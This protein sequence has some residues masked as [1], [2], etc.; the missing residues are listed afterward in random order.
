MA[1]RE[2]HCLKCDC[3]LGVIRDAKLKIGIVHMCYLCSSTI[4]F[5]SPK[6]DKD[7]SKG[8]SNIF[9]DIFGKGFGYKG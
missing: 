1:D 6:K 7:F 8:T 5:S 2:I 3:Y 9:E 4:Q